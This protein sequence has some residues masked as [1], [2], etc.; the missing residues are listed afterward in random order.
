MIKHA[1]AFS[2]LG[3]N[4]TVFIVSASLGRKK[5]RKPL[6]VFSIF[7]WLHIRCFFSWFYAQSSCN[8]SS[9]K[10]CAEWIS[11]K[12][13]KCCCISAVEKYVFLLVYQAFIHRNWVN[14]TNCLVRCLFIECASLLWKWV[15]P[16]SKKEPQ[17]DCELICLV[18]FIR[19]RRIHEPES[20]KA[21]SSNNHKKSSSSCPVSFTWI[22]NLLNK[23]VDIVVVE[24]C[25]AI[26]KVQNIFKMLLIFTPLHC[27]MLFFQ[28][29][30]P[31]VL[32]MIKI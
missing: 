20:L 29:L 12:G 16:L 21:F 8:S 2:T 14:F 5:W 6:L 24:C 4:K 32:L 9:I 17:F 30:M 27:F 15:F 25:D 3:V 13:E 28:C 1:S 11:L 10:A 22:Y 7:N 19:C 31:W 26:Q 18:L 23:L